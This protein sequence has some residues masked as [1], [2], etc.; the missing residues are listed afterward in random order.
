M[1]IILHQLGELLLT[2]LPTFFL[3][4]FLSYYLK[5]M[6]FAPLEK[7]LRKRYEETEGARKA[8]R[9]S[10]QAAAAKTAEYEEAIRAARAEIYLAQERAFDGMRERTEHEIAQARSRA[11]EAVREGKRQLAEEAERAKAPLEQAS[12]ALANEIADR[13]LH[14]RAA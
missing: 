10:L 4:I 13:I 7:T 14:R 3:L 8:A 11:D 5:Y 12:D 1:D 2:S 9:E 6:F